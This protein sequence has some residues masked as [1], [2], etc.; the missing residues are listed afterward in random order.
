MAGSWTADRFPQFE[1]A[2]RRLAEQHRELEDEPLHLAVAYQ[3]GPPRDQQDVYLFEVIGGPIGD[4][5]NPDRELFE[6]TFGPS[7]GFPLDPGRQ[8]HLT[9]TNP[10]ELGA[11]VGQ[12]WPAVRELV[13]A[14][15]AGDYRVL[16]ADEVGRRLLDQLESAA[17]A[18]GAARG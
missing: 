16:H 1:P 4:A 11:A 10:A 12:E 14:I 6:V 18:E 13:D 7:T 15:R 3:P 8:L 2:I 9:L 5:V 17:A